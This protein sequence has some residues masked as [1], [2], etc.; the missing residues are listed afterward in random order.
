VFHPFDE[1]SSTLAKIGENTCTP[2]KQFAAAH[3]HLN[4]Q[5]H[6]EISVLKD[7]NNESDRSS[8]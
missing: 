1:L 4:S 8:S 5:V 3:V 2:T 7:A 6:W